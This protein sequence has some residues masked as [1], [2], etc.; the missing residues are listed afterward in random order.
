MQFPVWGSSLL[1]AVTALLSIAQFTWSPGGDTFVPAHRLTGIGVDRASISDAVLA[2]RTELMIDTQTFSIMR[3]PQALA[4]AKRITSPKL[5]K[6]FDNAAKQSGLPASLISAVAYLESWG[7]PNAESPAGPKGVMQIAHATARSM[8]LKIVTARKYRVSKERRA[9]KGRR[10]KVTYKTVRIKTPYTVV[11]R[12]ERASP[13]KA[14]PAAARYLARMQDKFGGIDWAVFA[15][16]CG[17][18]CVGEFQEM[19]RRSRGMGDGQPTVARAFFSANPAYNRELYELIRHHMD[20]DFSPTYWFRI[21]KAQ[22]LLALYQEDPD[23]FEKLVVEYRNQE[24]PS[25]R[26]PHRLAVWLKEPDVMYKT[27]DDIRRDSG[28]RLVKAFDDPDRFGF[29]LR[30]SGSG[31]IGELDISNQDSYLEATPAAIGTLAYIAFETR[32]LHEAM[33]PKGEKFVPLDVT[34][35]VRTLD[36]QQRVFNRAVAARSELAAHCTGQVFDIALTNLPAGEREALQFVLDDMGW[37]GYLGF[38]EEHPN[39]GLLHIGC[40]PSARDFFTDV[41]EDALG[42]NKDKAARA[43]E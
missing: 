5:Q 24:N 15:Y 41:F 28:K 29:R 26:A 36:Y 4:G 19:V 27:C 9:V 32:R 31:A 6:I 25:I 3:D 7:D 43:A 37:D 35:L 16:H 17:E 42:K 1:S 14:I 8:G 22:K 34:G 2:R 38:V 30:K 23:Q 11:V 40:S 12:D 20:R 10:G 18:G 39:S 33:K 21:M 13:E